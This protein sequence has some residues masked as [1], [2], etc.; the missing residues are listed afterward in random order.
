VS[1]LVPKFTTIAVYDQ[2]YWFRFPQQHRCSTTTLE[3]K[4][5]YSLI[6]A[7]TFDIFFAVINAQTV[8]ILPEQQYP[9]RGNYRSKIRG[10]E[11]C[12]NTYI[13]ILSTSE[14]SQRT[15]FKHT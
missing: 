7:D 8:N 3:F 9:S 10:A 1:L 5:R 11:K 6:P 14:V 2:H 4:L 13:R 12:R 15:T